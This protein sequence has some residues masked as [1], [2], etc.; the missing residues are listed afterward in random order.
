MSSARTRPAIPPWTWVACNSISFRA[1][2]PGFGRAFSRPPSLTCGVDCVT[3]SVTGKWGES[4]QCVFFEDA[5][6][7]VLEESYLGAIRLERRSESFFVLSVPE[8]APS[9]APEQ[10]LQG[11]SEARKAAPCVL[12]KPLPPLPRADLR[13]FCREALEAHI[14]ARLPELMEQSGVSSCSWSLDCPNGVWGT[15]LQE[16]KLIRLNKALCWMP[17]D[18]VDEC[19][20]HELNHFAVPDHAPAFWQRMTDMMPAWPYEEGI[21]RTRREGARH[22]YPV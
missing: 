2:L 3:L 9:D 14:L 15:C 6:F 20:L 8:G 4:V 17:P 19:I 7:R 11:R 13:V 1:F 16:K 5:K 22:V 10:Y 12:G 21:L 18:V